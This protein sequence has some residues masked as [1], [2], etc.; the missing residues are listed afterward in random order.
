MRKSSLIVCAGLLTLWLSGCASEEDASTPSPSPS[1]AATSPTFARPL[2][3]EKNAEKNAD[4]KG[5]IANGRVP[6]LLQATDP[7]ERARQVQA[8]INVKT[9][10]SDPFASLPPLVTIKTPAGT[11]GGPNPSAEGTGNQTSSSP[12]TPNLPQTPQQTASGQR[13]ASN[14]S[15]TRTTAQRPPTTPSPLPGLRPAAPVISALPPLPEPTLARAVEV[16][17][18]IVV[19]GIAEAIVKAPNEST[20]RYVRAGQRLSNGQILVKRIEVNSG[21]D[22]IVILEQNGIEVSRGVGERSSP[23]GSPTALVPR[24]FG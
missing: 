22:P 18:V 1:V 8:G 23:A 24:N 2:V 20:S 7:E 11:S 10:R 3:A 14:P 6:G 16:S 19:G 9:N 5:E 12:Q 15:K 17:G 4:K 21:S 13:T